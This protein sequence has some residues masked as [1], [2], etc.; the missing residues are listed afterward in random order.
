[1]VGS[2]GQCAYAIVPSWEAAGNG[3]T[4]ETLSIASVVDSF[5]KCKLG[6][7]KSLCR[8]Q[9]VSQVLDCD[10]RVSDNLAVLQG[11]RRSVVCRI[12]IGEG[13][14]NEV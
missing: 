2:G 10:V 3:S 9:A 14:G 12:S 13:T 5:E 11:L 8:V 1:M 4:E 7:I 6:S